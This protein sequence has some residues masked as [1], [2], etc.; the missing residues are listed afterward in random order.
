MDSVERNV[1]TRVYDA[2]SVLA[3]EY[4]RTLAARD[5][6]MSVVM[7]HTCALLEAV[8]Y[9]YVYGSP[10]LYLVQ[11]ELRRASC[12][13]VWLVASGSELSLCAV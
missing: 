11:L 6:G 4:R 7:E 12:S 13:W 3:L 10:A 8:E 5:L 2:D 9:G 1:N